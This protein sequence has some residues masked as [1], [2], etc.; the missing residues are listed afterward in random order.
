LYREGR[1]GGVQKTR[2][3]TV[4][5]IEPEEIT[6]RVGLLWLTLGSQ[7]DE[8]V[9]TDKVFAQ[10]GIEAGTSG[11]RPRKLPTKVKLLLVHSMML[12]L[13]LTK[14]TELTSCKRNFMASC[15]PP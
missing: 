2:F 1:K 6:L 5:G 4:L 9:T 11:P 14:C 10:L 12:V 15:R 7:T 3:M 8:G 13:G